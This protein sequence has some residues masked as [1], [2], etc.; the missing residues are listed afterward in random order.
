MENHPREAVKTDSGRKAVITLLKDFENR[1]EQEVPFDFGF[2]WDA[3][4]LDRKQ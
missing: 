2:L 4:G 3:L 1:E